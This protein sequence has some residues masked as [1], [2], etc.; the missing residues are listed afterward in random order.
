MIIVIVIVMNMNAAAAAE[1]T[2]RLLL[3][4]LLLLL[5]VLLLVLLLQL[6]LL[7][8]TRVSAVARIGAAGISHGNWNVN[9]IIHQVAW[10]GGGIEMAGGGGFTSSVVSGRCVGRHG[11]GG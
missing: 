6:L 11:R 10:R 2:S 1:I 5:L 3:L 8:E 9:G 7:L 4:L